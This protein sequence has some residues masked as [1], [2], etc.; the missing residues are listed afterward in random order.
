MASSLMIRNS[1]EDVDVGELI[2]KRVQRERRKPQALYGPATY[3]IEKP[4]DNIKSFFFDPLAMEANA[5]GTVRTISPYSGRQI[6]CRILR[7]VSE[8][9]WIINLCISTSIKQARP[10]FKESTGEN[11]RGFR[12]RNIKA[13]ET[14]REMKEAEKKEA[15]RLVEFLLKTGDVEDANRID[16]LDKY[17]TKIIRDLYQLDQISA[18]LQRTRGGELC[19]FWAIDTA[20]IEVALPSTEQATGI[21]YAQVINNIPYAYYTKDDLIFDCM[22][23]RT[24]IEKA[25]Y[26]YS[27]VEQA[28]DLV[29]SS[30]N[31]FM[32][33]A[34]FFTENKL[35]RG[36]LLLNGPADETEI[37]DIEEYITG[38]LSGPPGAQWKV[39]IVPTGR[40]KQAESGGRLFEWVNL[41][42]TNKEM[43]FQNWFDLQLS[44]IAAMF[45]KS[46][47]ELGLH[48]QKS[49]PLIGTNNEPKMEASKSLGLGDLLTFMQ[50]HFNQILQ[51][52]NP[53]YCFEFVGY[54]KDDL[55]LVS[56][57]DKTEVDTWKT[58]N[59][60]RM[61]K[62]IDPIDINKV[63]NPADLPMN[64]QVVQLWQAAKQGDMMGG[65]GSPFG[66]SD[67]EEFEGGEGIEGGEA[68]DG[69][70]SEGGDAP[71]G[72]DSEGGDG[73]G[74]DAIES[75]GGGA[76]NKSM[77]GRRV[78]RIEI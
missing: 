53:D 74:W 61:E 52:K 76:V 13:M 55:R 3:S 20:T 63:E 70:D 56:E 54:E 41:Q 14:D 43:E 16:D 51:Q 42:G 50:K 60:K 73:S 9:A 8:K 46:M 64:V 67:G 77:S 78:V 21:K 44:G 68:P 36:L 4:N 28:I 66:M 26:G 37:Q 72:N 31:T 48:S 69:G 57:I 5:Y 7:R 40:T 62:G 35:P 58:L 32:Y 49:Q 18:E 15:R 30:I 25:G 22:N 38:L 65:G 2:R 27:V 10:Y 12:V 23:P 39:P 17:A 11:Q 47:E 71:Q 45:A 29:T 24:D 59:E 75:Q 33:N 34:G 6:S 1:G 19:A